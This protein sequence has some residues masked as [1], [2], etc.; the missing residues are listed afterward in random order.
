MTEENS[1]NEEPKISYQE[2]KQLEEQRVRTLNKLLKKY[3]RR[4]KNSLTIVRNLDTK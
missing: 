4:Q 3:R 2:R 1:I